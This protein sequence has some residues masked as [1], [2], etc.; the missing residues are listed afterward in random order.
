MSTWDR[1]RRPSAPSLTT[2]LSS[3]TPDFG[4]GTSALHPPHSEW[5]W[6]C[7]ESEKVL[8]MTPAD[9]TRAGP[10]SSTTDRPQPE[11]S[12][13]RTS[14]AHETRT[15]PEY[16]QERTLKPGSQ[17]IARKRRLWP[18]PFWPSWFD[19]FRPIQ[20]GPICFL[21][22]YCWIWCVSWWSPKKCGAPKKVGPRNDG[23]RSNGA[24][25]GGERGA[26]FRAFFGHR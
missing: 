8:R 24:P 26:K 20:F 21:P 11:K 23:A 25:K 9:N 12:N 7:V 13:V 1:L 16:T 4:P 2:Q 18:I 17:K 15:E 6:A 19:Q 5:S 22:I 10:P 3:C 14:S